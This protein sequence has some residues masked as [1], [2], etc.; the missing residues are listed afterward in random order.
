MGIWRF[1]RE[2]KAWEGRR[3]EYL[4]VFDSAFERCDGVRKCIFFMGGRIWKYL[5][6]MLAQ[7]VYVEVGCLGSSMPKGD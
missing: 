5:V 7:D 1:L 6:R 4:P 2:G 3:K